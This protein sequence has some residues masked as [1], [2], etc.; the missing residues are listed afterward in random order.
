MPSFSFAGS[1]RRRRRL[2]ASKGHDSHKSSGGLQQQASPPSDPL[3]SKKRE[4]GEGSKRAENA[5]PEGESGSEVSRGPS[6]PPSS[7]GEA[8]TA[9]SYHN[10]G[11]HHSRR[12][13]VRLSVKEDKH[14]LSS[15]SGPGLP[16]GEAK[17]RAVAATAGE[18]TE[19]FK[20]GEAKDAGVDRRTRR[21]KTARD[22]RGG[23]EQREEEEKE[24][25]YCEEED[26]TDGD[27]D[28]SDEEEEAKQDP[29]TAAQGTG[30]KGGY[31]RVLAVEAAVVSRF[32]STSCPAA[33][34]VCA[35]P[36]F[37]GS[38]QGC[39]GLAD[40]SIASSSSLPRSGVSV[41]SRFIPVSR[42]PLSCLPM[43][44]QCTRDE[45]FPAIC[46]SLSP[47]IG[48]HARV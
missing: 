31:E 42:N 1:P 12:G 33:V 28:L 44:T 15:S 17:E 37:R 21:R 9:S 11:Q 16:K 46:L 7:P 29:E 22:A 20:A 30:G 47:S 23:D 19:I 40:P 4:E 2:H 6:F 14:C 13:E 36:P 41:C 34:C 43:R 27:A 35:T 5:R 39:L 38:L 45:S 32:V 24:K 48:I 8:S 26:D 18:R 3:L 25:G 10:E